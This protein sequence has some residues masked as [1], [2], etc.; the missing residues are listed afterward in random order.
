AG[1]RDALAADVGA[2]RR[3]ARDEPR[4]VT[5]AH[6]SAVREQRVAVGEVS[7]CVNGDRGDLELGAQRALVE[8]FDIL[9]LVDV[10]QIAGVNLPFGERVEHERVVGIGAVG[11]V[12]GGRHAGMITAGKR[13][14]GRRPP[15]PAGSAAL[16]AAEG[17]GPLPAAAACGT[18]YAPS[19][20]LS[21]R[22]CRFPR[23]R[24][25]YAAAAP[26]GTAP[27]PGGQFAFFAASMAATI[28]FWCRGYSGS[29]F[30][31]SDDCAVMRRFCSAFIMVA[32]PAS[33]AREMESVRPRR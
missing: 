26:V 4:A 25:L 11:D 18:S 22:D 14:G 33:R 6:G 31:S 28:S 2:L 30:A 13:R 19:C 1:D 24:R 17:S 20:C 32:L 12:N 5:I 27:L 10:A 15:T 29:F 7:V 16:R 9:Q 3:C 8:R 21:I 23:A